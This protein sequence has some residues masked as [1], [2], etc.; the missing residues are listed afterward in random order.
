MEKWLWRLMQGDHAAGDVRAKIGGAALM[1]VPKMK[2][3][4]P[5]KDAPRLIADRARTVDQMPH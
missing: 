1:R 2:S 3:V 5:A 4:S